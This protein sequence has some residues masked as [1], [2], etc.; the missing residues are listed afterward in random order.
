MRQQGDS[1]WVRAD[2]TVTSGPHLTGCRLGVGVGLLVRAFLRALAVEEG[3][4][5]ARHR[6]AIASGGVRNRSQAQLFRELVGENELSLG[7]GRSLSGSSRVVSSVRIR[8]RPVSV[9]EGFDE[10]GARVSL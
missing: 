5:V 4:D 1:P 2:S 9:G 8:P 7:G 6:R 3:S 10:S